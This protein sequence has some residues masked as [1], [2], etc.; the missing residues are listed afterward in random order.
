MALGIP[1]VEFFVDH[2]HAVGIARLY[3]QVLA[4]PAVTETGEQ[5]TLAR[6]KIGRNQALIFR[7]IEKPG[8]AYDGHHI[9]IYVSNFSRPYAYLKEHGLITEEVRNRQFSF[10]EIIDPDGD[11]AVF[12]LNTR[13]AACITPCLIA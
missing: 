11:R 8:R 5:G 2:D 4:A 9:A 7:E 13:F 10:R 12:A 6:I 3:D 1:Y